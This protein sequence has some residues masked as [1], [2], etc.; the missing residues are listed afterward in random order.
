MNHTAIKFEFFSDNY[1]SIDYMYKLTIPDEGFISD[2]FLLQRGS[3]N[4]KLL[5]VFSSMKIPAGRFTFFNTLT[6]F[7]YDVLYVNDANNGWYQ[8]GIPGMGSSVDE[9][10][11]FILSLART[12]SAD[13]IYTMGSSMG[14][15]GALLFGCKLNAYALAFDPETLLDQP[16]SRSKINMPDTS[17]R[18]FPDLMPLMLNSKSKSYIYSG[19]M[20][21]TDLFNAQRVA[22]V[23]G[24]LVNTLTDQAHSSAYYINKEY[25]LLK[26]STEFVEGKSL[27]FMPNSGS[28]HSKHKAVGFIMLCDKYI[29]NKNYL[30]AV[31]AAS[32]AVSLA[33]DSGAAW[34]FLG[35]SQLLAGDINGAISSQHKALELCPDFSK[36]HLQLG[37]CL[38]RDK[39]YEHA[40][41][42]LTRA[43][44]IDPKLSSAYFQR[45]LAYRDVCNYD[46]AEY[47]FSTALKLSPKNKA[48]VDALKNTLEDGIRIRNERLDKLK[49]S[50]V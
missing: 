29:K 6:H 44:E 20:D 8:N 46:K 31:E 50:L 2:Y 21:V 18:K 12:I 16:G 40:I 34:Y 10:C 39:K 27:P 13:K 19:E 1:D 14:G 3:I 24:C 23:K 45:G 17:P 32:S 48:F 7:P 33:T 47:D 38:R 43:T 4:G 35:V 37:V 26:L 42:S 11:E 30:D 49:K 25:G 22:S 41:K 5:V 9:S 36:I 28:L 15:Y